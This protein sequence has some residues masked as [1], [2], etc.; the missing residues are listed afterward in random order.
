MAWTDRWLSWARGPGSEVFDKIFVPIFRDVMPTGGIVLD[1]GAGEGRLTRALHEMNP[2]CRFICLDRQ[3]SLLCQVSAL[4]PTMAADMRALPLSSD[5][6][7][8][9]IACMTLQET[10]NPEVAVSEIVRIL[11]PR[12]CVTLLVTHP[13]ASALGADGTMNMRS[14]GDD[15]FYERYVRRGGQDISLHGYRYSLSRY[16]N[17]V[18]MV[19]LAIQEVREI[20][21]DNSD[22]WKGVPRFLMIRAI[23]PWGLSANEADP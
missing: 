2:A 20:T 14:Y 12:G 4:T 15:G 1:L 10:E 19:G 21:W 8:A 17:C 3:V 11:K 16:I 5:S 7:D 6:V 18:A 22:K 23:R 13:I 9:V